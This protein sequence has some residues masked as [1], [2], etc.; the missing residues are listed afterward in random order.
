MNT[1]PASTRAIWKNCKQP[2]RQSARNSARAKSHVATGGVRTV[3]RGLQ[4]KRTHL[5]GRYRV[6][7]DGAADQPDDDHRRRRRWIEKPLTTNSW[8][9][10][11]ETRWLAFQPVSSESRSARAEQTGNYDEDFEIHAHVRRV[12]L[13]GRPIRRN[14]RSSSATWPARRWT[15]RARCGNSTTLR[16]T[17]AAR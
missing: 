15:V 8:S 13:P 2:F 14:S 12:A 4:P 10:P 16:T 9:K 6:V 5:Q 7:A 17:P 3:H 1:S 11:I